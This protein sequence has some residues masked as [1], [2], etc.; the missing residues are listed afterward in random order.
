VLPGGKVQQFEYDAADNLLRQPG[1][2]DLRLREGNRLETANGER[3]TYNDRN[4]VALREGPDG[5]IRYT[6]DSRDMLTEC[7]AGAMKWRAEYDP[8][9]RRTHK[10]WAEKRVDFYW[11]SDRL[12]AEVHQDGRVRV[13]VY[14]DELAVVPLLFLEYP[15][16]DADPASGR[17]YFLFCDQIGTPVRV[18]DDAGVNVWSARIDPYGKAHVDSRTRIDMPLRFPGHYLDAETG[19]HYNRFRYYSPDLGRYLQSDPW[20]MAGG[21]NL[22]AY[23]ASPLSHV[24]VLG[25]C[26]KNEDED[27]NAVVLP[28]DLNDREAVRNALIKPGEVDVVGKTAQ[29]MADELYDIVNQRAAAVKAPYP[30]G[31]SSNEAGANLT[32]RLDEQTGKI[33]FALNQK[34]LPAD[35]E[36]SVKGRRRNVL[37]RVAAGDPSL[38]EDARNYTRYRDDPGTNVHTIH[39]EQITESD[40]LKDMENAGR[41]GD[42]VNES[43]VANITLNPASQRGEL[44]P[45]CPICKVIHAG[46]KQVE[47]PG[48]FTDAPPNRGGRGGGGSS[49]PP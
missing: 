37:N 31:L 10:A 47:P 25:A 12:A 2:K 32:A 14:P 22:Y 18:K 1:L 46:T 11:D 40:M 45:M 21:A 17:R 44:R 13:Y 27:K 28:D 5:E 9:G 49:P 20:G 29:Q 24:D 6:Y 48:G 23:S 34:E 41:T 4:H 19:L 35:L 39:G 15:R 16:L 7:Q 30:Q 36:E 42:P 8:L 3:F 38:P 33:Y 43:I 26:V